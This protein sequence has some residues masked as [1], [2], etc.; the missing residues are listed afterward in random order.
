MELKIKGSW[1]QMFARQKSKKVHKTKGARDQ[2]LER[3]RALHDWKLERG[4]CD[5]KFVRWKIEK[6]LQDQEKK[7]KEKH[8]YWVAPHIVMP[9]LDFS[10]FS[11]YSALQLSG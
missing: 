4:L 2:K 10:I 3:R 11:L 1:D 8:C 6:R 9:V 7:E 5:W